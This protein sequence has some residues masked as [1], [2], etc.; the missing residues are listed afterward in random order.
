MVNLEFLMVLSNVFMSA[1][2]TEESASSTLPAIHQ[3]SQAIMKEL[4]ITMKTADEEP[5][6]ITVQIQIKDPEIAL[7]ADARDKDTNAL[8]LKVSEKKETPCSTNRN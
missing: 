7:L 5:S 2:V 1:M 6:Q 4:P 3:T 8:F